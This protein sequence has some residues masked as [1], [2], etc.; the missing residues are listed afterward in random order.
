MTGIHF[1]VPLD[2][3]GQVKVCQTHLRCPVFT[4]VNDRM[5]LESSFFHPDERCSQMLVWRL[6]K[7]NHF[8]CFSFFVSVKYSS[9]S[10]SGVCEIFFFFFQTPNL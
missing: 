4:G 7:K 2:G 10:L 5:R 1:L 8:F 9:V 6:K 3:V